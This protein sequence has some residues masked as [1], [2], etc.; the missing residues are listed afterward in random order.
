M[1][2]WLKS[3][4]ANRTQ[5]TSFQKANSSKECL[6]CGVPQ[7]SI[8]G[9]PMFILYVND[10]QRSLKTHIAFF[11]LTIP[12]SLSNSNYEILIDRLNKDLHNIS[13]WLKSN[14][15]SLNIKKHTTCYFID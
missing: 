4:L 2:T 7:G 14:K 3:D 15:L 12:T 8:L 6:I 10:L 5:Y 13:E 9:P 11:S 1:H